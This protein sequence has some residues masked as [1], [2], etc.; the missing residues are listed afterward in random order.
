MSSG[1]VIAILLCVLAAVAAVWHFAPKR[2]VGQFQ[3]DDGLV[4]KVNG[5]QVY[6]NKNIGWGQVHNVDIPVG[7]GDRVTFEVK[8]AGGPGGLIG[9]WSWKL[10]DYV[11]NVGT[12]KNN[13]DDGTPYDM[14]IYDAV[15]KF[16]D[17]WKVPAGTYPEGA[18]WIWRDADANTIC[19]Y[20]NECTNTFTWIA[21]TAFVLPARL[22]TSTQE[23]SQAVTVA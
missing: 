10:K 5:L 8:N 19:G 3:A 11:V 14:P 22:P 15:A 17:P 21:P 16:S 7:R 2:L 18:T 12:F 1:S 6:E 23:T 13:K 9:K 4:I 20:H